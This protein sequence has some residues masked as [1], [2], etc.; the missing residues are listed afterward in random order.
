MI[1][2]SISHKT[3]TT[4]THLQTAGKLFNPDGRTTEPSDDLAEVRSAIKKHNF[5]LAIGR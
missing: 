4:R 3:P 5:F 1:I 2:G